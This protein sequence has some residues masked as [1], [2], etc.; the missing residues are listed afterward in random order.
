MQKWI[1]KGLIVLSTLLSTNVQ[2]VEATNQ[3]CYASSVLLEAPV[4]AVVRFKQ[5]MMNDIASV[6]EYASKDILELTGYFLGVQLS[7][8]QMEVKYG[9]NSVDNIKNIYSTQCMKEV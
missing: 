6:E 2:A 7:V 3:Y 4:E 9:Y 1:I 5:R 8:L